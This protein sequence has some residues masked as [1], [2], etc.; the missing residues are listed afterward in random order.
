MNRLTNAVRFTLPAI[1][2]LLLGGL[3]IVG[4]GDDE[5]TGPAELDGVSNLLMMHAN[6]GFTNDVYFFRNGS[7]TLNTS[8]TYGNFSTEEIPNGNSVTINAKG[9]DGTDLTSTSSKIDSG[10]HQAAIFTGTATSYELFMIATPDLTDLGSGNVAVRFVHAEKDA[11]GR[12]LR[13]NTVNG[14][15]LTT[16]DITY[17]TSSEY[18]TVPVSSTTS[19]WIVDPTATDEPIQ[20]D[21]TGLE[22]GNYYTVVLFG[23]KAAAAPANQPKGTLIKEG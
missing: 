15:L 1:F 13:V 6:P 7:T 14:P 8:L 9:A 19:F 20:V 12:R 22:A 23:A 21:A 17:K 2:A 11:Q 18:T 10:A 4:C 3:T 16:S 5:P